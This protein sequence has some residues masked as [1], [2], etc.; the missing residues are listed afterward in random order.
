MSALRTG[1]SF[2]AISLLAATSVAAENIQHTVSPD[3]KTEVWLIKE[4]DVGANV[5]HYAFK[6]HPDIKFQPGDGITIEAGGCVQTGGVGDTWKRYVDPRGPDSDKYYAGTIWI[7][8]VI[9]DRAPNITRIKDALGTRWGV[10][11]TANLANLYLMLG[12]L[13]D[14]NGDNGYYA[15]DNGTGDQ[16]KNSVNAWVRVTVLHGAG[17]T[18]WSNAGK[19]APLDL[20]NDGYDANLIPLNPYWEYKTNGVAPTAGN[21]A[22]S[23]GGDTVC[24]G[25]GKVDVIK[26]GHPE[27]V[28]CVS[29]TTV[30][31]RDDAS[32]WDQFLNDYDPF[33]SPY[34]WCSHANWGLATYTG[35]LE[36][37]S[38]SDP[39]ED[40]DYSWQLY[41]DF[42][43]GLAGTRTNIEP[44][45]DSEETT[46]Y[47]STNWWS[48]FISAVNSNPDD[49]DFS[50]A[51]TFFG[52][53]FAIVTGLFGL[54]LGHYQYASELHPVF[55]MAVRVKEDDPNDEHWAMF[56]RRF[57][58]EGFCSSEQHYLDFLP[59]NKFVFQLPLIWGANAVLDDNV[60]IDF[61]GE[62]I[63]DTPTVE[64]VPNQGVFVS[65]NLPE[66]PAARQLIH[67]E[68]HLK[69]NQ[70]AAAG[71]HHLAV[72][73]LATH[74]GSTIGTTSATSAHAGH[75][76][77]GAHMVEA[78]E[79]GYDNAYRRLMG[80]MTAQQ[81]SS[82][83]QQFRPPT[84]EHSKVVVTKTIKAV[85]LANRPKL[86]IAT[87]RRPTVRSVPDPA[88][89]A[90][91]KQKMAAM[92][93]ALGPPKPTVRDH[94]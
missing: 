69:W 1:I 60:Q 65:F 28:P 78:P 88:K 35:Q 17:G 48:S 94:R 92:Q 89:V 16:C 6:P 66:D 61:R 5:A 51:K 62:H 71:P 2:V 50:A 27:N 14:G 79:V 3:G 39:S 34:A 11:G 21:P 12:Y 44:E 83:R 64:F 42:N 41:T 74:V 77:L 67:G 24:S 13:D 26:N 31:S 23:P 10:P 70:A 43:R 91:D 15:H 20:L 29:P 22:Q 33:Q 72:G 38:H 63:F 46:N 85:R 59:D 68:V 76:V 52:K 82:F 56:V 93:A 73:T 25:Q 54:D 75:L 8:G 49:G 9:G 7:P 30:T 84:T 47:F 37:E 57:G 90:R 40:D 19:D 32:Y 81:R 4:P 18:L 86:L 80:K 55:A 87:T 45:F 53:K 58:D 36:F